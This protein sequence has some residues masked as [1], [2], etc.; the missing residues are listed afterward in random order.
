MNKF[1][2]IA[3]IIIK[4]NITV[5]LDVGC[6]DNILRKYLPDNINYD[7]NDLFQNKNNGVKYVG[8]ILNINIPSRV[9]EGVVALDVLE[10]T[11]NPY[12][13]FDKLTKITSKVILVN[14][15]NTYDLKTRLQ[16][17]FGKR[18]DKYR[19]HT[20]YVLDRHRWLM[21]YDDIIAF[22]K[23]QAQTFNLTLNII[24]VQYGGGSRS[25]RSYFSILLRF[26]LPKTL[27][28]ASV[29]GVFEKR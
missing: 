8:D 26:I 12:A 23:A 15:P 14:L 9:Y 24:D 11:D 27:S 20:D 5:L 16:I 28:T 19:F 1:E 22:Y 10:H 2:I 17:F 6:R 29:I 3:K 7:G 13:V 25:L 21:H 18:N 4:K